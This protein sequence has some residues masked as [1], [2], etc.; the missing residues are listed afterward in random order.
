MNLRFGF[1]SI[2][3]ALVAVSGF[4]SALF[5]YKE[6]GA[7]QIVSA[8]VLFVIGVILIVFFPRKEDQSKFNLGHKFIVI[9]FA[10]F[11]IPI[12]I[13]IIFKVSVGGFIFQL[14]GAIVVIL[15]FMKFKNNQND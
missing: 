7:Y 8:F 5:G 9:G 13:K 11:S 15:G 1:I 10:L 2:M 14:I 6:V 12:A 3:S 4:F